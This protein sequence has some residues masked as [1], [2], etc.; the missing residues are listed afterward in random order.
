M[1]RIFDILLSFFA[2]II[3]SPIFLLISILII[4][5]SRGPV[6]FRQIRVGKYSKDFL[7][8]KFRTMYVNSE[9]KSF[10]TIGNND[11]RI[12]RIG[13][14]LRRF[15]ID[16]LPQLINVLLGHMSLVGPRPEVRKYVDLYTEKQRV[17]LNVKP[18]ITD[19]ASIFF[20]NENEMLLLYSN[21]EE[22]YMSIIVPQKIKLNMIFIERNSVSEYFLI[23]L[24]TILNFLLSN[25]FHEKLM[26]SVIKSREYNS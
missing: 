20:K 26:N 21:A 1:I 17:V 3:L 12:T 24:L 13:I 5:D 15:K 19:Y 9:F 18:G 2:L 6:F 11:S 4:F 22:Y 7:L 10:I 23:I 16:E 14:L 8:L 25:N